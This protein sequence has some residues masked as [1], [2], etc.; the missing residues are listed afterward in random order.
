[1]KTRILLFLLCLASLSVMGQ[2]T[3]SRQKSNVASQKKVS[4]PVPGKSTK[5][6]HNVNSEE[7]PVTQNVSDDATGFDVNFMCNV[8]TAIMYIDGTNYGT[9]SGTR[10]LKN[11][12][13]F[14]KLES[15]DYEDYRDSIYVDSNHKSFSFIMQKKEQVPTAVEEVNEEKQEAIV[16]IESNSNEVMTLDEV[17]GLTINPE[18]HSVIL[19]G[20]K[21]F[22]K[23]C[24]NHPNLAIIVE[25]KGAYNE[26]KE[27]ILP[28]SFLSE[29][30]QTMRIVGIGDKAFYKCKK[31]K[32][33][34]L[35]NTVSIVGSVAFASCDIEEISFSK[36]LLIIGDAAFSGNSKLENINLPQGI[37]EI[38]NLAFFA[39]KPTV[40][41]RGRKGELYIPK[42]VTK[43]G[44]HAFAMSRNGY[45]SW[46]NSKRQILCLPDFIN[47]E[48]CK[49][50][51]ISKDSV[52]EYFS[53]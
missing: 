13:H 44:D 30:G 45:G 26:L 51:G 48:N 47:L 22:Y 29:E 53:K 33:V 15:A 10:F 31:I 18:I 4:K 40:F 11:G 3:I 25:R 35:P 23:I 27:V 41:S 34:V 6:K 36:G 7:K 2:G 43:I 38:G 12:S 32:R 8:S 49:D 1:M 14:I 21:F 42:T 19:N 24:T 17:K 9:A 37:K 50:F 52:E 46:F 28:E 39:L 5:V 16:N 20:Q